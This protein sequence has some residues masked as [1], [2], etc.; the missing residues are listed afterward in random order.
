M[1][2]KISLFE[3]VYDYEYGYDY[4][5]DNDSDDELVL[6]HIIDSHKIVH[7]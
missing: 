2:G 3:C 4:D 6:N 5:Y 1:F 7:M